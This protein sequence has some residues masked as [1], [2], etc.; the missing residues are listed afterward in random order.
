[1]NAPKLQKKPRTLLRVTTL[2]QFREQTSYADALANK[3]MT[4]GIGFILRRMLSLG[5]YDHVYAQVDGSMSGGAGGAGV[6][7]FA[8]SVKHAITA[9]DPQPGVI[10]FLGISFPAQNAVETETVASSS[11]CI[12]YCISFRQQSYDSRPKFVD[13]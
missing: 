2:S 1:M 4:H 3:A 6:I 12:A 13:L 5:V 7:V 10:A 8:P 11:V 9:G